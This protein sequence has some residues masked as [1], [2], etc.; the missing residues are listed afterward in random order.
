LLGVRRERLAI[1]TGDNS[2][3][4]SHLNQSGIHG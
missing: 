4:G 3:V 1:R 2:D